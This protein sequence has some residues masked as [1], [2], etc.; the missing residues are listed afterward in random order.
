L[1]WGDIRKI[2]FNYDP[3][4]GSYPSTET[5]HFFGPNGK[6]CVSAADHMFG[7]PNIHRAQKVVR[8]YSMYYNIPIKKPI[9]GAF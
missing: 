4:D 7:R 5:I 9:F 6:I 8:K 1:G 2:E 3:G